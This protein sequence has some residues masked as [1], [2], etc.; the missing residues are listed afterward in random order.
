MIRQPPLARGMFTDYTPNRGYD[1][2]FSANDQPRKALRPLLSS[3][4]RLGLD[5]LN[6]N[7]AAAGVLLKRLGATFRLNGSCPSTPGPG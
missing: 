4:G 5:E 1:E 2:Y 7:H 6:R 3:L